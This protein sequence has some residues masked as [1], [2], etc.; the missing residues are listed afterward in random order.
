M[1]DGA[2]GSVVAP[3]GR[4]LLAITMT[5]AGEKIVSYELIADPVRLQTRNLAVLLTSGDSPSRSPGQLLAR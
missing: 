2:V 1:I 4:L 5:I 3:R